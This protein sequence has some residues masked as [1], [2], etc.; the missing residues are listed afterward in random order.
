[1]DTTNIN[2][3]GGLLVVLSLTL[4]GCGSQYY[5]SKPG[6]SQQQYD[7]DNFE[8]LQAAQQPMLITPTP[9]MPAGGMATNKDI[10]LACFRAKGYIV[11][12]EEERKQIVRAEERAY[13]EQLQQRA[14]ER[15]LREEAAQKERLSE[16]RRV[17]EEKIQQSHADPKS[18][19]YLSGYTE[20]DVPMVLI[21]EG[22][23]LFGT[24]NARIALPAFYIDKYEV[25]TQLYASF[26]QATNHSKPEH[27]G[28]V[29]PELDGD[30]PVIGVEYSDADAYCRYYGKRLPTEQEWEKAARCTDGRTYPWGNSEPS[31]SLA[32][33]DGQFCLAFCNVYAEKLKPVGSYAAGRSPY[34]LYDMAGN[35]W[36]WVE[37]KRLRG[38]S[39]LSNTHTPGLGLQSV[40]RSGEV[41]RTYG[42]RYLLGFRCAQDVR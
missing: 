6:F 28:D 33:F 29:R 5:F 25:T 3:F 41:I 2:R 30:K 20:E 8:C 19:V 37:T 13:H 9:G 14:R 27:W 7:R 35:A 16:M 34:G 42:S 40:D 31:K 21:P 22:E 10:Y 39:W 17:Q 12:N 38:G 23:F 18:Y 1:M 11:Q 36:E 24:D 15:Q 26:M 4:G 32:N